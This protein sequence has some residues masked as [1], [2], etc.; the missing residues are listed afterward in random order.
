[1][2]IALYIFEIFGYTFL[3]SGEEQS[4]NRGDKAN[5]GTVEHGEVEATPLNTKEPAKNYSQEE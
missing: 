3:G 1:M 4:W 5:N 2:T